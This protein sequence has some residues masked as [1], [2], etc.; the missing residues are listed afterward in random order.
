MINLGYNIENASELQDFTRRVL[1]SRLRL[2]I[3]MQLSG[4]DGMGWYEA[5]IV[6]RKPSEEFLKV[7]DH[8]NEQALDNSSQRS[9]YFGGFGCIVESR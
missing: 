2:I 1:E 9:L 4:T 8:V 6:P 3:W 5:N 7:S